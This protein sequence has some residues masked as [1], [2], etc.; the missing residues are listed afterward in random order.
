MRFDYRGVGDSGGEFLGFEKME[1]DLRSAI[2]E[3]CARLPMIRHL[4]LWG[5]CDASSAIMMHAYKDSR[6]IGISLQNPWARSTSGQAKTYLKHYYLRRLAERSFWKKVFSLRF[7]PLQALGVLL[8]TARTAR[9]A[10]NSDSILGY[11]EGDYIARMKAGLKAYG[12]E[13][14]L[15][16]S[17]RDLIAREFDELIA[18]DSEWQSLIQKNAVRRIDLPAADHTF[19]SSQMR[20]SVI[21]A[22]IEWIGE[23][24]AKIAESG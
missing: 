6:V 5:E 3:F 1:S 2:N 18:G 17:G 8:R 10:S 23:I 12:G 14:L 15:I 11:R 22:G 24:R 4:V 19:S 20:G 13:V 16:M 21:E 9:E 7:N